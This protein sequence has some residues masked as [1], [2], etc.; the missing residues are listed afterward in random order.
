MN[1]GRAVKG[2]ESGPN[3][4][5]QGLGRGAIELMPSPH[6]ELIKYPLEMSDSSSQQIWGKACFV[7]HDTLDSKPLSFRSWFR[8]YKRRG[9]GGA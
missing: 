8:E 2:R 9:L 5:I 3:F 1:I 7:R 4:V 6:A